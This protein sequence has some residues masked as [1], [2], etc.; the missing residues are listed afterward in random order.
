M[1]FG[2]L[3]EVSVWGPDGPV[4]VGHARQR[5]V[6]AALLADAN[7]TVSVD[8]LLDRVWGDRPPQ[9]ARGTLLTY[10]TR[11]RRAVAPVPIER[12]SNGY[13][14][15]VARAAFDLHRFTD[16]LAQARTSQDDQRAADLFRRA[17]S[18][19]RGE[20]LPGQDTPWA[21]E[22]REL[23]NRQRLAAELDH[24]DVL[25]RLGQ[26]TELLAELLAMANRHPLDERI[27]GQL[28]L[29]LYRSGRL[30]EAT[31]RYQRFHRQLA[32][33]VGTT[34]GLALRE[35]HHEMLVSDEAEAVRS[36]SRLPRQLPP[37][38]QS[39][40][41]R[42]AAMASLDGLLGRTATVTIGGGGGMGKTS[43]ALHWAH[44]NLDHFPDGQLFVNLRGFD[45]LGR[46][47]D[48]ATALRGFL[49]TLGVNSADVP[50]DLDAQA[51]LYRTLVAGRRMLVL[52][53]NAASTDQVAPLL[54]G[55][56][57]VTTV[58]TS[59]HPLTALVATHDAQVVHLDVLDADESHELLVSR[60]GTARMTEE[61]TAV[62]ELVTHC[63]GLPLA[64]AIVAARARVEP[65]CPLATLAAQLRDHTTRLDGIDTGETDLNLRAV[66][67][68]SHNAL[69]R[70]AATLVG[71]LALA[72]GPD[73]STEA[74]EVLAGEP[75][76]RRL[77]ELL[78]VQLVSRP[79]PDRYR[80]HD[81]VRL[82]AAERAGRLPAAQRDGALH[83]LVGY[84]VRTGQ[85]ADRL[86][87]PLRPP[88]D[89]SEATTQAPRGRLAGKEAATTWLAAEHACLL[90]AQDMAAARGWH[91]Q[92]WELA[93]VTDTWH[94]RQ[95]LAT[96]HVAVLRAAVEA[97]HAADDPVVRC[98][99][100]RNLG[101]AVAR[102]GAT[103]E[104]IRHLEQAVAL[105]A[106]IGMRTD[107]AHSH[108][109]LAQTWSQQGD[110][111]LAKEHATRALRL[112][113]AEG[114]IRYEA[115]ALNQLGWIA[116][117]LGELDEARTHCTAALEI[118]TT[119]GKVDGEIFDSLGYIE[120]RAGHLPE[121]VQRY[122]AA[123]EAFEDGG[124][125]YNTASTL[126]QLGRAYATHGARDEA[127]ATWQQALDLC[128]IQR[129]TAEV[130]ALQQLLSEL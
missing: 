114:Q 96:D 117:I 76:S 103:T 59:R 18:L 74:V 83:R 28:I 70:D 19:W 125:T 46:P 15:T 66:F 109:S 25:L 65:D 122:R 104:A 120:E 73:I 52:L 80:M 105:A 35:L 38:P 87:D 101:Q 48:P 10:L 33:E 130:T 4:D 20:P 126:T 5:N 14:L 32:E 24:T 69:E 79:V 47:T 41:G 54:P 29:A 13:Q 127:R 36:Q 44:E 56:P 12:R 45:P 50:P 30:A 100:Y 2:L 40:T 39:F 90:A 91:A 64:L 37:P 75:P 88:Y 97:A 55:S 26:H 115:S 82:D 21:N 9:T 89:L 17:L 123:V 113:R 61:P 43:L 99:L 121:A 129:R 116:A 34:P 108:S 95:G 118:Q 92:T 11:L 49:G 107:Q 71:L 62:T 78:A 93:M 81:L 124:D 72:P 77:R 98:R 58:V 85:L 16:M 112:H 8:Q 53:D 31:S 27:Q 60:L 67:S 7:R 3:G 102:T 51:N 23:L 111:R 94:W 6:L 68:V 42:E 63:A 57:T 1:E 110:N 84:Y 86:L 128:R 22:F 119:L 106:S